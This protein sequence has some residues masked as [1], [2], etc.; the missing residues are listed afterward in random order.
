MK[1]F[2]WA[3]ALFVVVLS[4]IPVLAFGQ[5]AEPGPSAGGEFVGLTLSAGLTVAFVQLIRRRG[6]V[7]KVPGVLRPAI[8]A[9]L[10]LGGVYLSGLIPGVEIDLSPI[11]S[12]FAAGGGASLL[13]GIGKAAGFL[14]SSGAGK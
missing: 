10:G 12:L 14:K 1:K 5:D 11:A 8:V 13:F 7:D 4:L 2:R 6:L 3:A 9:V